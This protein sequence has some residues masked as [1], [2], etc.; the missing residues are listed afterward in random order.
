M[1]Y[2]QLPRT[3]LLLDPTSLLQLNGTTTASYWHSTGLYASPGT[4]VTVT[5]PN[6]LLASAGSI[7]YLVG[8]HTDGIWHKEEWTRMPEMTRR[9]VISSAKAAKAGC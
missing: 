8:C 2:A 3:L 5:L 6:S 1:P 9:W 7:T 4:V